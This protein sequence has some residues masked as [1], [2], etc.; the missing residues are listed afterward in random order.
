MY[1]MPAMPH[2]FA[3]SWGSMMT[4]VVPL[5]TTA[6]VYSGMVTME[7]SICTWLS[8][9]PGEMIMSSRSMAALALLHS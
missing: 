7:L 6:R 3:I 9:N 1:R 8:M 4:V 5:G 2:K